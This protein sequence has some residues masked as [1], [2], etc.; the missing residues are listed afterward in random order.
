MISVND[1]VQ[2]IKDDGGYYKAGWYGW[3][4][5]KYFQCVTLK[6]R[7]VRFSVKNTPKDVLYEILPKLWA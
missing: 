3:P 2:K 1:R 5:Y 7:K 4:E 6:E